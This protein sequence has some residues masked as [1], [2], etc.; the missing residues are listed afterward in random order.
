MSEQQNAPVAAAQE[1]QLDENQIMAHRREMLLLEICISFMM[2]LI[3]MRW[4]KR[5]FQ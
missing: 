5:Q 1:E 4:Q 2:S 3:R